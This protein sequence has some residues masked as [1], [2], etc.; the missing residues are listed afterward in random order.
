MVRCYFS[1]LGMS[2][3][4]HKINNKTVPIVLKSMGEVRKLSTISNKSRAL[5]CYCYHKLLTKQQKKNHNCQ[6]HNQSSWYSNNL[7]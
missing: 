6:T 2:Y 7:I 3:F 1:Y 4:K 5:E